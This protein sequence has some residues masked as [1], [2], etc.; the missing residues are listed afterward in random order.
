MRSEI[1]DRVTK[2]ED[3]IL[4]ID[5]QG[6]LQIKKHIKNMPIL[7]KC[8]EF[9][10]IG[11]PDVAEL[12]K[13]LRSRGTETEESIAVRLQNARNELEKWAQYDYLIINKEID[14]TVD[15]MEHLIDIM[16]KST[17]RLTKSGFFND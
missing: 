11:P 5:V 7:E 4:D 17:K 1:I 14:K 3:V 2:G 8:V 16:H 10:F 9:V 12:E 6:A 13:R 15:D